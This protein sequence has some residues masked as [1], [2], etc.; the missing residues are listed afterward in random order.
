MVEDVAACISP[1]WQH[2]GRRYQNGMQGIN[3]KRWAPVK[4]VGIQGPRK[5]QLLRDGAQRVTGPCS[6]RAGEMQK[7]PCVWP[8]PFREA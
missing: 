7:R 2:Q 4:V 8:R 5:T 3:G 6:Y 1:H